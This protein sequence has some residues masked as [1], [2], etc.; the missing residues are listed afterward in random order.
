MA[1]GFGLSLSNSEFIYNRVTTKVLSLYYFQKFCGCVVIQQCQIMADK[2]WL[3]RRVITQRHALPIPA[4][5]IVGSS[6]T[7]KIWKYS[8]LPCD[9][10][11]GRAM[12]KNWLLKVGFKLKNCKFWEEHA[13]QTLFLGIHTLVC[14]FF[15]Q[16]QQ[17]K[18]K[19]TFRS[20][21][22]SYIH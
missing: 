20:I 4:A 2:L 3:C 18:K 6:A 12:A 5:H 14:L 16:V 21:Y 9:Y 10:I 13:F 15:C 19:T 1:L 7:G 22:S 11:A 17:Q 8:L